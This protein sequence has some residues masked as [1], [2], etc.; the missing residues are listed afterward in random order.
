MGLCGVAPLE[1][2]VPFEVIKGQEIW[3]LVWK[4][5]IDNDVNIQFIKVTVDC[6]WKNKKVSIYFLLSTHGLSF[7]IEDLEPS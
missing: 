3:H 7:C 2:G 1:I 4:G 6:I 5:K